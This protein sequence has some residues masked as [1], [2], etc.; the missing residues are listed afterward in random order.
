MIKTLFYNIQDII[1]N[2]LIN[3]LHK[4][5]ILHNE[6]IFKVNNINYYLI[7]TVI[8]NDATL[9]TAKIK[10]RTFCTDIIT[11]EDYIFNQYILSQDEI[12]KCNIKTSSHTITI[13]LSYKL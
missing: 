9:N 1:N 3:R 11:K 2:I 5:Y 10:C 4:P 7:D 13:P 8:D 12:E 6:H